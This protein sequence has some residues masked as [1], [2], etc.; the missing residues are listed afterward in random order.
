MEK[1]NTPFKENKMGTMPIG[2]LV[3]SMSAPMMASMLFQ[4]LYNIVDSIFVSKMGPDALNALSL[5]FP[6]QML[7]MAFSLGTSIG[8]NALISRYLGQKEQER[9]DRAAGTGHR[10]EPDLRLLLLCDRAGVRGALL[11]LPDR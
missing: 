8:M 7:M 5:A 4:A 1:A 11:P 10:P 6:F 2:K 3:I 9:A